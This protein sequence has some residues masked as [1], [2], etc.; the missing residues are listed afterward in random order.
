MQYLYLGPTFAVSHNLVEPRMR[1]SATALLFLPINLIGLGVGPP[2]VGWLSDQ[3]AQRQFAH[4]GAFKALCPGGSAAKGAEAALA[5]A[6]HAAAF[7]GLKWAIIIVAGGVYAWAGIHY[8]LA[9][10]TLKQ[11]LE[12]AQ[13]T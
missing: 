5:G 6:C 3:I 9:A 1:A 11:D 2:L 8:L 12:T 4:A 10:R 7:D 13:A